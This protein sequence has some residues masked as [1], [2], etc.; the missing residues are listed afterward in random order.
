MLGELLKKPLGMA[1]LLAGAAGGPYVLY[2]TDAGKIARQSSSSWLV[3]PN[4]I[5]IVGAIRSIRIA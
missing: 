2:E 5:R 1:L 4:P 3:Q